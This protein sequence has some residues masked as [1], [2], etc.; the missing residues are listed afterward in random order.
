MM[1]PWME[2]IGFPVGGVLPPVRELP[3]ERREWLVDQL[4]KLGVA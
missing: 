1:K 4:K 2:A 3:A